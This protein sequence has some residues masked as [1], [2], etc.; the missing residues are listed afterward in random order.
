MKNNLPY[1]TRFAIIGAGPAGLSTALALFENGYYNVTIFE[2][3]P[4]VGGK[5][6]SYFHDGKYYDLGANLTTPRYD[7]IREL[8]KKVKA[9]FKV[10]PHRRIVNVG[11]ETYESLAEASILKKMLV[12]FGSAFYALLRKFT[13]IERQGYAGLRGGVEKPFREWLK[14]HGLN[15]FQEMF[16]VL[17]VSYGYGHVMD[18]SAAYA[19]KFFDWTHIKA[20]VDVILGKDVSTS[21]EFENGFQDFWKKVVRHYC[22]KVIKSANVKLINRN[23]SGVKITYTLNNLEHLTYD[24]HFDKIILACPLQE[25]DSLELSEEEQRLFSKISTY[26][27]YVTLAKIDGIP[28]VSTYIYPY[29][30]KIHPGYP[31]VFYPPHSGNLFLSYAYGG[32]GIDQDIVRKNFEETVKHPN[33][34]ATRVEFITTQRWDYFPHIDSETMRAGFYDEL[35]SLQGEFS[36]YYTGEVLSFTLVELI[37]DYSRNLVKTKI[38]IK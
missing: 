28:P 33:I 32:P 4:E 19:L 37:L 1:T 27:Y 22:F 10:P 7:G 11:T 17:F 23:P 21:W 12:R 14:S 38:A 9:D 6:L 35:E 5:C 25:L 36:T 24:A 15:M 26:E 18:L 30:R 13:G 8:A 3:S 20:S 34:G 2:K 29:A 16:E 31:T